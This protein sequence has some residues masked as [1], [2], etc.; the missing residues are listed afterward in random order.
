MGVENHPP[1]PPTWIGLS[2][3]FLV[4]IFIRKGGIIIKLVLV[5]D[6][7]SWEDVVDDEDCEDGQDCE[8]C[9]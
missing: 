1:F 9:E 4:R 7:D 8:D 3:L 6:R 5:A 2:L